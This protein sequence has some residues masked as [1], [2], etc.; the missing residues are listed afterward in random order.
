MV[1][2]WVSDFQVGAGVYVLGGL[3][4]SVSRLYGLLCLDLFACCFV[5]V[6]VIVVWGSVVSCGWVGVVVLC[7]VGLCASVYFGLI[8]CLVD[9]HSFIVCVFC[10]VDLCIVYYWVY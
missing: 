4:C 3:V 7:C 10:V 1:C 6:V 2:V 5:C 9:G 8:V